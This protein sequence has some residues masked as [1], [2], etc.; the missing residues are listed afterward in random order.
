MNTEFEDW[1]RSEYSRVIAIV[2]V[3]V[4]GDRAVAEDAVAGAFVK[5]FERWPEVETMARPGAWVSRVAINNAKSLRRRTYRWVS[6]APDHH[7]KSHDEVVPAET[8]TWK[9]LEAL[10]PRQRRALVLRY[11]DDLPQKGVAESL[12]VTEG[13]ASA[14][15]SQARRKVRASIVN[16]KEQ[17]HD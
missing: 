4:G 7:D 9:H 15:L 2:L 12:G 16:T 5:A 13:T 17:S 6:F 3:V 11:V 10:T 1:Y 14:T 8:G